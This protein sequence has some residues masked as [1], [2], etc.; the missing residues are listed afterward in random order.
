M[1]ICSICFIFLLNLPPCEQIPTSFESYD[2]AISIVRDAT[3]KIEEGVTTTYKSSWIKRIEY[4]SCDGDT[5]YVPAL[6][7]SFLALFLAHGTV[8]KVNI[9]GHSSSS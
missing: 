5:S 4:Y 3:F 1:V 2:Q 9:L 6:F 8:F 7:S